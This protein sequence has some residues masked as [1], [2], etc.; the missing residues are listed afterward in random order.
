MTLGILGAGQLGRM[1]ALAG[2][3][4]GLRCR[5]FDEQ[6]T[7]PPPASSV[8]EFHPARF[9]DDAALDRFAQGLDACTLEFENVPV[10]ALERIGARVPVFPG[11]TAL[12]TAQDRA[13]EKAC[14]NSL[15]IP[16][17]RFELADS[18]ES[19]AGA[20]AAVGTPC[21]VKT[22]RMGYDGKGQC[23][24][25]ASGASDLD[26]AWAAVKAQPCIV[27]EF[28][29]FDFEVSIIGARGRDGRCVFYPLS[30]NEHRGGILRVSRSPADAGP[31][32]QAAAEHALKLLMDHL[33]YVG[34]LTVEFFVSPVGDGAAS[35]PRLIANEMA[36][37][38]HNSG[39]WTIEGADCSQFECHLR[40]VAGLPLHPPRCRPSAMVNLIG[41]APHGP[42]VLA[43]PGAHLHLYGKSA[44]PGRKVGH[45]TLVGVSLGEL[46]PRIAQ[47]RALADEAEHSFVVT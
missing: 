23:V 5:C 8:A 36:P 38:V 19:L 44:R 37:R 18:R 16:T 15:G 24:V 11:P 10:A 21:V 31:A 33:G 9:D 34:V 22:R 28:I 47:L 3:P 29:P 6:G 43:I 2:V 35:A 41:A 27:E 1:L 42:D 30:R 45:V 12:A 17:T 32:L 26:A 14:F 7:E 40:A 4:L 25:R 39:H 46:E 20:V 13:L